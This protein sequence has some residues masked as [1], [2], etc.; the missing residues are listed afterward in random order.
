MRSWFMPLRESAAMASGRS[1]AA[2]ADVSVVV[3]WSSAIATS[4]TVAPDF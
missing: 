2:A 1:F 4:L 3:S